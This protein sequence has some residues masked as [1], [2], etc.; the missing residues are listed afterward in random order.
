MVHH[1]CAITV[2]RV[3]LA[4]ETIGV[5]TFATYVMRLIVINT[6][7]K[8]G[9]VTIVCGTADQP[10]VIKNINKHRQDNSTLSVMSLN[11]VRNV[12]GD[13]TSTE[14]HQKNTCALQNTVSSVKLSWLMT[15]YTNVSY[16]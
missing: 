9:N 3:L 15:E 7:A 4:V 12:I 5:N 13:I 2:T 6:P 11:T 14:P 8:R 1:T 10:T 16:N